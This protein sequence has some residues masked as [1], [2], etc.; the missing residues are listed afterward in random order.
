VL[1]R[2]GVRGLAQFQRATSPNLK[3]LFILMEATYLTKP[4]KT[5]HKAMHVREFAW[6]KEKG[7]G[8][9]NF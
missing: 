4:S 5:F 9:I 6:K 8:G 2:E 3:D 7:D 1:R